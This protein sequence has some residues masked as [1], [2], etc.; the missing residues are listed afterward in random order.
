MSKPKTKTSEPQLVE[1]RL[2]GL[3]IARGT[4]VSTPTAHAV[5]EET[6]MSDSGF[7]RKPVRGD[8]V[9]PAHLT[10]P[11]RV[12]NDFR[13]TA[14]KV[15]A[16]KYRPELYPVLDAAATLYAELEQACLN[17]DGLLGVKEFKI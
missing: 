4:R 8:S 1:R 11:S 3:F 2:I 15:Y 14:R 17:L 6:Y 5:Y 16:A 9:I 7:S 12:P 10:A 13:T